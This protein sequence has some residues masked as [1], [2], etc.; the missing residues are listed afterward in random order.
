[1]VSYYKLR[2]IIYLCPNII[3]LKE[4]LV[5]QRGS[6]GNQALVASSEFGLDEPQARRRYVKHDHI[7]I[8]IAEIYI[9]QPHFFLHLYRYKYLFKLY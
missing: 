4:A 1:M 6:R 3:D 5:R 8:V 7:I 9:L 2:G